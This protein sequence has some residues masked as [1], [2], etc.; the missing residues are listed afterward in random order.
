[1]KGVIAEAM[2]AL[3][4]CMPGA[5]AASQPL[6]FEAASVKLAP[7]PVAGQPRGMQG[8]FLADPARYRCV[9]ASISAM[10]VHA[11]GLRAYQLPTPFAEDDTRFNVEAKVPPGTTQ[12]QTKAMLQNLLTERFK[13]VFHRT[14]SEVEGYALVVA[15]GGPKIKEAMPDS[16]APPE[17]GGRPTAPEPIKNTEGFR[18]FRVRNGFTVSQANGLTRWVGTE[19]PID[20]A[21]SPSLCGI[22][23]P[24]VGQ[25]VVDATGLN[26]KFEL[27]LT[28]S[29]ESAAGTRPLAAQSDGSIVPAADPALSIFGALEQQ[30]GL[31]LERRKVT[32]NSFIIDAVEKKPV[33]N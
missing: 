19:V 17:Q 16:P 8:C 30:L 10:V 23:S 27:T 31:R 15:K 12:E 7:P 9:N 3:L 28:F 11:Y 21:Q 26:G 4:C 32:I 24:I 22:L 13:L 18:N 6:T 20:S 1:M 33:E 25:P 29:S 5:L 2:L 14:S